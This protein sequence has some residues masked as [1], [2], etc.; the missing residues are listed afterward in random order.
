MSRRIIYTRTGDQGATSLAC[1]QRLPKD[2]LRID[3]YGTLDELSSVLGVISAYFKKMQKKKP[4]LWMHQEA[5]IEWIQD[6]LFTLSSMIATANLPAG[7]MPQLLPE[8]VTFLE[9]N[10]DDMERDLPELRHFI[11]PGGS[12]VVSFIHLARTI[13]RRAE[14]VCTTLNR[15]APLA[16][17]ILPFLNRLSDELFVLARWV[18]YQL[19][20]AETIWI[21]RQP[22]EPGKAHSRISRRQA[23][24]EK[25]I[26]DAEDGSTQLRFFETATDEESP[27]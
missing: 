17:E 19:G 13:C 5:L 3:A 14:R 27:S 23:L 25:M 20:E 21:G 7:N 18:G 8:D 4:A 6:K 11:L 9:S 10:I 15:Q 22:P 1:G 24:A 12:E 2:D 26:Q 16:P